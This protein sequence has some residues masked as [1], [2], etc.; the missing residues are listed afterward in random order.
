MRRPR[1]R[2]ENGTYAQDG[3]TLILTC[4]TCGKDFNKFKSQVTE[5]TR[6]CSMKCRRKWKEHPCPQCGNIVSRKKRRI[7][8]SRNCA[9]DYQGRNKISYICKV[10]GIVF[11]VSP[12]RK[13]FDNPTYCS[14]ACRDKCPEFKQ[15]HITG[16][17]ILQEQ[18]MPTTLEKAGNKILDYLQIAYKTQ[19]L[20]AGKFTVDVLLDGYKIVIQWDGNYWHGF[21][22]RKG[23]TK[24]EKRVQK[25][26]DLDKSQDKYMRKC[27]YTV[28]R[29]WEH[30]VMKNSEVVGLSIKKAISTY[31]GDSQ[32]FLHYEAV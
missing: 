20:I 6:Y 1:K 29:F 27:G 31:S 12:S 10:C 7:F 19:V 26:M 11:R 30:E 18:R 32:L 13:K 14:I 8:C 9:N 2:L 17:C 3:E 15:K 16:N 4:V 22:I 28:L 21:K 25:R 23:Y 5:K 24:P